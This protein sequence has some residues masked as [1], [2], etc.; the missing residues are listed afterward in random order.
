MWSNFNWFCLTRQRP[1]KQ[2][3]NQRSKPPTTT[4]LSTT[5]SKLPS[6]V[7]DL[8]NC[9]FPFWTN[10]YVQVVS[11]A[12][13]TCRFRGWQYS[14]VGWMC[15]LT[16]DRTNWYMICS[17]MMWRNMWSNFIW[18]CSTRQRPSNVRVGDVSAR[19]LG[20]RVQ[21]QQCLASAS[22]LLPC[23]IIVFGSVSRSHLNL[24]LGIL[25]ALI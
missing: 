10:D 21:I 22:C 9:R 1:S 4:K 23:L 19:E 2:A 12:F 20:A 24:Y 11:H 25:G 14:N 18:F 5:W 17:I 13:T 16:Q 8:C 15:Q 3:N 7:A 6:A